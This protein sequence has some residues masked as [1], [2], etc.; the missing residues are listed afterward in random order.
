MTISKTLLSAV[1]LA[2]AV[3]VTPVFGQDFSKST[4]GISG[5]DPVAYFT[6]SKPVK[7]NGYHVADYQGVT[8]A[9]ANEAN[10]ELFE[11]N[12]EKYVPAYGGWCAYGVAVGKKFVADPQ[13]WKIV[14]GRLYLNLD[15]NIQAKWNQDVPGYIKTADDNWKEIHDKAPS[16]L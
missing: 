7:G 3:V 10:K 11:A 9:F 14:K 8:Y 4:P 5:Y 13:V 12:P 2:I 1:V 16:E 15:R 6:E